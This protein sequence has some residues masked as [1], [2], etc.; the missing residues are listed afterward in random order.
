MS[1][2]WKI[3]NR[4]EELTDKMESMEAYLLQVQNTNEA[5]NKWIQVATESLIDIQKDLLY[6]K[7]KKTCI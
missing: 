1:N 5:F 6:I 7:N 3:V 4:I 2:E